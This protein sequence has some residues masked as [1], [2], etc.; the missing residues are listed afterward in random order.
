MIWSLNK[1]DGLKLQF[2][3]IRFLRLL[4]WLTVV[5]CQTNDYIHG[6][7]KWLLF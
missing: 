2:A 4:L 6:R 7:L 1:L 3:Q 5:H